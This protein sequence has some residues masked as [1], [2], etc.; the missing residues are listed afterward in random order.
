MNKFIEYSIQH[1]E[2]LDFRRTALDDLDAWEAF[3]DGNEHFRFLGIPIKGSSRE[4]A[5]FW[6]EL[7][8]ERYEKEAFGHLA[9]IHR[10]SGELIGMGG[11]IPRVLEGSDEYE[12]AYSIIPRYWGMG[13]ATEI[14]QQMREKGKRLSIADEF[15]SI[16]HVDH[17]NS[18]KVAEKNG[19]RPGERITYLNMPVVVYRTENNSI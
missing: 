12:I 18:M 13:Y 16:I 10:E 6:I 3:F 17:V 11:I 1:S 19:M 8:L 4:M 14:S 5:Q 15:I 9:A 7:Q 2:R